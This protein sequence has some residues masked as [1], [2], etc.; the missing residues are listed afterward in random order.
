[1]KKQILKFADSLLSRE[2]T[3]G[4]KGGADYYQGNDTGQGWTR[5]YS[6]YGVVG[7][8]NNPFQGTVLLYSGCADTCSEARN[9]CNACAIDRGYSA[10]QVSGHC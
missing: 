9:S 3:K 4:V 5:Y 10:S 7:G 2:E 8:G 1:M 6:C